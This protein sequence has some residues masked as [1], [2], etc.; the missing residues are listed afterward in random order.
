MAVEAEGKSEE[1]CLVRIRAEAVVGEIGQLVRFEIENSERLLFAGRIGTVS[2]VK[3]DGEFLVGR[4]YS[5]GGNVVD[6]PGMAGSFRKHAAV[7]QVDGR[8]LCIKWCSV[9]A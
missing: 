5:V 7:G 8:L 2:A 6:W 1:I 4:Q 9:K 3:E